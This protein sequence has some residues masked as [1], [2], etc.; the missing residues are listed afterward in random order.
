MALTK[1]KVTTGGYE[2]INLDA[3]ESVEVHDD[4]YCISIGTV[5]CICAA[6]DDPTITALIAAANV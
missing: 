2:Y 5:G 4:H 3:I 1:I 6:L